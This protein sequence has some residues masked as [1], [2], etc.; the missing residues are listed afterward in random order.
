MGENQ[1]KRVLWNFQSH[2][3]LWSMT[4]FFVCWLLSLLLISEGCGNGK[5]LPFCTFF[6]T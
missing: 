4:S 1:G 2:G 3:N 6:I 5:N